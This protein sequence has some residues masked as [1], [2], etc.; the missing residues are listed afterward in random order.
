[1]MSLISGLSFK[2]LSYCFVIPLSTYYQSI[3]T[4]AF[5]SVL[6]LATLI[7]NL[8]YTFITLSLEYSNMLTAFSASV[9]FLVQSS[10]HIALKIIFF[11]NITF[12]VSLLSLNLVFHHFSL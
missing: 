11:N 5:S 12:I 3:L 9:L 6:F 10:I 4:I 2:H 8:V 1:M 7:I